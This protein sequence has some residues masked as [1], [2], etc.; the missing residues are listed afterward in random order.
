MGVA[1]LLY[2]ANVTQ[3][4]GAQVRQRAKYAARNDLPLN[5]GKPVFDLVEPGGVG[6]REMQT[7][8]GVGGQKGVHQLGFVRRKVVRNEVDFFARRLGGNRVGEKTHELRASVVAGGLAQDLAAL[9][10]Q[11]GVK[12]K[13]S[14]AKVFKPVRLR[15]TGG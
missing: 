12:G 10:L 7:H 5:F 13:G 6:R 11:G 3:Q 14:V 4:F 2:V 9:S 8:V 15:P 1:V